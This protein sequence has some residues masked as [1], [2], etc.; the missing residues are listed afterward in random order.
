VPAAADS[1]GDAA[2]VLEPLRSDPGTSAVFTDVDGTLAPIVTDPGDATVPPAARE[3]LARL[4]ERYGLVGCLSG[5]RAAEV[6]EMIGLDGLCYVG[7]HG[8]ERILPGEVAPAPDPALHDHAGAALAYVSRLDWSELEGAGLRLEDKGPIQALHWRGAG[9]EARAEE[10]AR[11]VGAEAAARGLVPHLGRKVLE[12][13]PAV[14][15]DKGTALAELLE[16][17]GVERCLYA[18]DDRTDVDAFTI[19]REMKRAGELRESVCVGIASPESPPE[20]S[21]EA[22][23]VVGTPEEFLDLLRRLAP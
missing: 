6:R 13:R 3:A 14:N 21:A 8:F 23:L 18:G 22:D 7:N 11:R 19:L 15:L 12:V 20:V 17:H 9:D 10:E 1:N 5:R 16:E 4:A 2:A